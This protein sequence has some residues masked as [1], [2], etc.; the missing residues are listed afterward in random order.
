M[1]LEIIGYFFSG[2]SMSCSEKDKVATWNKTRS[3][4]AR[5][6][7]LQRPPI[8]PFLR[9]YYSCQK[10]RQIASEKSPNSGYHL[11]LL[12]DSTSPSCSRVRSYGHC[13]FSSCGAVINCCPEGG[14]WNS[15]TEHLGRC[16]HSSEGKVLA[17]F[18]CPFGKHL[19]DIW[20]HLI[21]LE[22]SY[23]TKGR[24]KLWCLS[25]PWS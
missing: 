11:I 22:I 21:H 4:L 12:S 7:S 13:S 14:K 9:D 18:I 17:V 5:A 1:G 3:A 20:R 15:F 2:K 23:G 25:L 24:G 10:A 16:V 8:Q 19:S 6:E